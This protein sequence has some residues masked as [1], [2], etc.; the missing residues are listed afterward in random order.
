MVLETDGKN[1]YVNDSVVRR[2]TLMH[3]DI[4]FVEGL[5]I[6]PYINRVIISNLSQY[7]L[8]LSGSFTKIDTDQI[9]DNQTGQDFETERSIFE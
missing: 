9:N 1:V 7:Q 5:K 8:S 3:G 2:K 6:I 4:I